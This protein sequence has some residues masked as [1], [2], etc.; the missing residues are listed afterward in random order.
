MIH[1]SPFLGPQSKRDDVTAPQISSASEPP[2]P[3]TPASPE[4]PEQEVGRALCPSPDAPSPQHVG[5]SHWQLGP[6]KERDGAASHVAEAS[7][8]GL[9]LCAARQLPE[10]QP[11]WEE[12]AVV[13]CP[14]PGLSAGGWT[15]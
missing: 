2:S 13:G 8:Y 11:I 1:A 4:L 15:E 5:C 12:V 9:P 10:R 3:T 14:P 7:H 6:G